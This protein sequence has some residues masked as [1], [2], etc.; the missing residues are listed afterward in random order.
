[1]AISTNKK[2][3]GGSVLLYACH[4]LKNS[5]FCIQLPRFHALSG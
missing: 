4:S 3:Q 1:M 2:R 5:T